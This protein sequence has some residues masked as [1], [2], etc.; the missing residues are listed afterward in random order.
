M[1]EAPV[2]QQLT[3]LFLRLDP[4]WDER[5]AG[6][7]AELI[8]ANQQ[9]HVCLPLAGGGLRQ[10]LLASPLVGRPGDYAPLIIDHGQSLYFA[11]HWFDET[12][13]A[14]SLLE[15]AARRSECEPATLR[16]W[17]DRLFP[18]QGGARPDRQKLAAALAVRQPLLV[19]S[20]GP[21]TGKT[22]TVIR[23]LTLLAA[24]SERPLVM[25]LA[26]PTGKAAARLSDSIRSA[27]SD[28]PVDDAL[29]AQLPQSAQT[30]HRLLGLRPGAAAPRF[31]AGHPLPLDVLVVDE[32]SMIDLSLM[33]QTV[34]ALPPQARL[35]MLG[36]R[37]QLASVEAGAVLGEL[38]Q[39]ISFR[40]DTLSWLADAGCDG[41]DPALAASTPHGLVDS[42]ALLTHS[43]RF[44]AESGIGAL[45]RLVNG[46]RADAAIELLKSAA[47]ADLD[48]SMEVE[49]DALYRQR[50]VYLQSVWDAG[51]PEEI[52]RQFVAFMPLVSERRQVGELNRMIESRL[53]RDG[54]KSPEQI[55]YAGRPVM[56]TT[57]DYA[58]DL[59]NGDIGFT[60]ARTEGLRVAFPSADGGWRELAPGRLPAHETVYAMTVH[61]SQGSEFGE[62]WLVLPANATALLDRALV[63]TAVTRTRRSFKVCG[64]PDILHAA[65]GN[66]PKRYSGLALRVGPPHPG[67][68]MI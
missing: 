25:A 40:P 14:R 6:A 53:E 63:Y 12:R 62:V 49:G 34:D 48:W 58:L 30:L 46:N 15:R 16:P 38:C 47:Y 45:S 24:L 68:A 4:A 41:P 61:K 26:A 11:R 36:D 42:I 33:A 21:G 20:G 60:V 64:S 19:I 28:L 7:L 35:I 2:F 8:Q 54:H 57:N 5:C 65:I 27:V 29:K 56:I 52:Q 1:T 32:A 51:A 50:A 10:R 67:A 13:L 59:F 43:H 23:L 17:L 3:S 31:H 22:T 55:W 39:H 37:D 9:G 18:D 66:A 44:S